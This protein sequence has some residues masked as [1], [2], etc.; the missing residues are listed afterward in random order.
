MALPKLEVPSYEL[1]LPLS[2]KKVKYRPFLVKEQKILL[3][4]ME[5]G[6]AKS[7]Q[8]SIL[9]VLNTC[10]LTPDFDIFGTPIIDVEY[11]FLNLRA[12]S[13]G[14]I[15]ESK[16]RCNNEVTKED[17]T[18]KECGNT[19]ETKIN[20]TEISPIQ[21]KE[22]NPEIKLSDK[23]IVK[24]KYPDFSI[25]TDS[26]DMNNITDVT[27]K[28]IAN[29]IEHIF[30]GEQFYYSKETSEE[31]LLEFIENLSQ[32]Q[33]EKME[34]FFN[35]MPRLTKKVEMKC[36]KCGFDHTFEVE[37]LESFFG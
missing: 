2:K 21:D 26:I 15:V 28:L 14:E 9:D 33:F 23:I 18:T 30:D 37:G 12:K 13:V 17:G 11:M 31:E 16:Y 22:V 29:C 25:M 34:D 6:D 27:F 3:M 19:M 7:M 10:I 8:S 1:E 32:E 4:A 35:N 5:S 36:G 24:M 20:L